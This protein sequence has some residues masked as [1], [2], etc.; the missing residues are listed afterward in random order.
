MFGVLIVPAILLACFLC[1]MESA[2][3]GVM[4]QLTTTAALIYSEPTLPA[5]LAAAVQAKE[6]AQ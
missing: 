4:A 5:Q 3:P 6:P 2:A 1:G